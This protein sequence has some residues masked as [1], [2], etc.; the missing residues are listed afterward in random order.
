MYVT[1]YEY[2][3]GEDGIAYA[4]RPHHHIAFSGFFD[5]NLAEK[6]WKKGER[7]NSKRLVPD[8]YGLEGI[9]RYMVKSKH[10]RRRWGGST[11]LTKPEPSRPNHSKFSRRRVESMVRDPDAI[12][13]IMEQTYQGYKY[14]DVEVCYNVINA[15]W[16]LYVRM[17]RN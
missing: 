12:R 7:T 10:G 2:V 8:D 13:E 6:L 1:E 15:G 17:R 4:V 9:A 14:N 3:E 11:N 16:Y 5:R